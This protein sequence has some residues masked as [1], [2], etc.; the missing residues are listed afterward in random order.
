MNNA[1]IVS[2]VL[3]EWAFKVA[4]GVLPKI[5]IPAES[6]IGKFMVGIL[7]VDPT[8]YNLWNE[9][10]FLAQP[11]IQV[12]VSPMVNRFL[13]GMGDEQIKEVVM[14]YADSFIDQVERK[15]SI[16][17]FGMELQRD[18]FLDLKRMLTEKM[19]E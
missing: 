7:G 11:T 19:G 17:L 18:A 1:E 4:A 6:A 15:G 9:L 14:K 13:S 10:G 2:S 12:V 16:N 5:R 3:S 8:H